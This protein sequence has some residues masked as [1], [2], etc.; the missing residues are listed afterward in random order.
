MP[1][2]TDGLKLTHAVRRRCPPIRIIVASGQR[3]LSPADLPFDSL[4]FGKPYH[5]PALISELR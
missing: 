4:F 5:T 2:S 3:Q 1:G